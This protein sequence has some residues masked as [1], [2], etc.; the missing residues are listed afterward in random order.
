[1][2]QTQ[3]LFLTLNLLLSVTSCSVLTPSKARLT[4]KVYFPR[5]VELNDSIAISWLFESADYVVLYDKKARQ[6]LDTL[7]TQGDTTLIVRGALDYAFY[8]MNKKGRISRSCRIRPYRPSVSFELP[9]SANDDD[10][11]ILSW[12]ANHTK[13]L[14]CNVLDSILPLSGTCVMRFDTA[15]TVTFTAESDLNT[16]FASKKINIKYDHFTVPRT[17]YRGES[18]DIKWRFR[19]ANNVSI[20]TDKQT[21]STSGE[22]HLT[23]KPDSSFLATFLIERSYGVVDTLTSPVTVFTPS[24]KFFDAP[25]RVST[26]TN[27]RLNWAIKGV[28]L[29]YLNNIKVPTKDTHTVRI[30]STMTFVLK[31]MNG[32]VP[33]EITRT[34][35]VLPT[36]NYVTS[37]NPRFTATDRRVS[38]DIIAVDKSQYPDKVTLHMLVVDSLGNYINN[39]AAPYATDAR[40][41]VFFK[42]LSEK[43]DGHS[44]T[45]DFSVKEYRADTAETYNFALALDHSG[46]MASTI[47]SLDSAV[48]NFL[49]AKYDK[50]QVTIS[51]FDHQ[52]KRGDSL[53]T[54]AD[55]IWEKAK[56]NGFEDFGGGGTALYAGADFALH[57]LSDINKNKVVVLFTDGKDNSSFAY[58]GQYATHALS[59]ADN[60]AEASSRFFVISCG[61]AVDHQRLQTLAML[62]GGKYYKLAH[63]SDIEHVFAE[64]PR[65]M[66]HHYAITYCPK[67][68]DGTHNIEFKFNDR[69]GGESLIS[70]SYHIGPYADLLSY[71]ADT[72]AYWYDDPIVD[73]TILS[74]LQTVANFEFNESYLEA[75]Y[76]AVADAFVDAMHNNAEAQLLLLGHTD[77]KGSAR[78]CKHLGQKRAK[79]V[80]RYL[81]SQGINPKRILIR[82]C[83]KQF[84]IWESDET[85]IRAF[86]NRR[87]DGVLFQDK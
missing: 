45:Q 38:C 12:K 61:D 53:S 8:G 68:Q 55:S 78:A 47:T 30:D 6:A 81:V 65:V 16:S 5:Q 72:S 10:D 17:L 75:E 7:T 29:A 11:V 82:S 70:G 35:E 52:L 22:G 2:K 15:T 62:G 3:V 19:K 77:S 43:I 25:R 51:K 33:I 44:Y 50:D 56:M 37:Y 21:I 54:E 83:G 67:A 14:Y 1:M 57:S 48:S 28:K 32:D 36:R 34:I 49:E 85:E 31:I 73:K 76:Y 60:L 79:T 18:I 4:N 24:I 63:R 20:E 40:A 46:S 86:E 26:G 74:P 23:L 66:R 42:N 84:P 9:Q 41:K 71:T 80:K 59:L 27:V 69:V 58:W 64:L 87:V 39:L 13:R